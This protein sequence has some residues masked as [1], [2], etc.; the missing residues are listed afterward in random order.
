MK[1]IT[2]IQKKVKRYELL[3]TKDVEEAERNCDIY[4]EDLES[5]KKEINAQ[6]YNVCVVIDNCCER[7]KRIFNTS[8][9]I[10]VRSFKLKKV[11]FEIKRA[12]KKV[13]EI[14]YL[15]SRVEDMKN[16]FKDLKK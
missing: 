14:T 5:L 8:N 4:L 13:A 9:N 15:K 7:R 16:K 11:T 12:R 10:A 2:Q 1:E 6:L 3:L